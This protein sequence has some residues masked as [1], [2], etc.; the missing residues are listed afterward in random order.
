MGARDKDTEWWP[1][2]NGKPRTP[3][4]SDVFDPTHL[5]EQDPDSVPPP[6][7]ADAW[8]DEDEDR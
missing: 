2:G 1:K 3:Q 8:D 7:P 5:P 6:P 4:I